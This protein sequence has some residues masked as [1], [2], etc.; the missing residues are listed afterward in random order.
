MTSKIIYQHGILNQKAMTIPNLKGH[1]VKVTEATIKNGWD[2]HKKHV[3]KF[4]KVGEIYTIERIELH[5]WH[6]EVWLQEIP[7]EVFNSMLF[8]DI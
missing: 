1:K 2:Y 3:E 8:E 5:D 6:T 7:N 4:L